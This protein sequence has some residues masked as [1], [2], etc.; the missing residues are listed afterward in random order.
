MVPYQKKPILALSHGAKMAGC[1]LNTGEG[2]LSQFHL[3]SGCD[4]VFQIGTAKFGVGKGQWELDDDKLR[5]VAAH[6][7]VRMFEIKISQGAKPGKGGMLPAIKVTKEIAA[8][9]SIPLNKDAISPNRHPEIGNINELLDFIDRVRNITSK[10][11]G[12]KLVLGDYSWLHDL[13]L[14]IH[15][16]G[17]DSAPDFI[18]LDSS[19]GGTGA[20]P[21]SLSDYV[22]LPI[23]EALPVLIDILIKHGLRDRIKVVASGKLITPA[24]VAWAICVGADFA[25]SA[26]GFLFSLGCIQALRCHL[27]TCPTGITTHNKRYTKGLD[28]TLKANR[29]YHYAHNIDYEVGVIAHSCGVREA[30]Q[31]NRRHARIVQANGTS[32]LLSELYPPLD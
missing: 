26:R 19:D 20:S 30:R 32:K 17:I 18:H 27:N 13:C 15:R 12:C 16:R 8:A 21:M 14:E 29:V 1:W 6:E 24:E 31:L 4:V 3:D 10:P 23:Q 5:D 11:T 25:S 28:P 9:R 7:V 22:G 2:G